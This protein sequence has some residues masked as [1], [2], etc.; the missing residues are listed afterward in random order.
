MPRL[1]LT[2]GEREK[3]AIEV[4]LSSSTEKATVRID[5]RI[6]TKTLAIGAKIL[7]YEV[8]DDEKHSIEVMLDLGGKIGMEI[9]IRVDGVLKAS[10]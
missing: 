2:V 8:G 3:H 6:E 9:E 5:G 7:D 1:A 10:S 4:E